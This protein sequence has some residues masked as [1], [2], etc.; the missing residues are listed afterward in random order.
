M[1]IE[2]ALSRLGSLPYLAIPG[3]ATMEEAA[4]QV[5]GRRQVRGIYVVDAE[6]RLL[7]TISL[8]ALVRNITSARHRP[9]FHT[10]SL[11]DRI[12]SEKVIDL[13][14]RHVIFA[15]KSEDLRAV[16]DRM[17]NGNIKEIPVVDE[18][19]RLEGVVGLL[20]LWNLLA[21]SP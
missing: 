8:G 1:N 12:T 18:S 6:G 11:L 13:M 2:E 3:E 15:R 7:G 4:E 21:K 19:Q 16:L 20:D 9:Q 5:T 10:R 14:D 17:A